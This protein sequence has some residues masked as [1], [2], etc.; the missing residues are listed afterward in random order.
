MPFARTVSNRIKGRLIPHR[1]AVH[2]TCP[3]ALRRRGAR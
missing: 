3:V 2:L 1:S